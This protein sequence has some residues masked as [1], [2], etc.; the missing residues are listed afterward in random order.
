[1]ACVSN[2]QIKD[3]ST[4]NLKYTHID[5]KKQHFYLKT[6]YYCQCYYIINIIVSSL[7]IIKNNSPLWVTA[8]VSKLFFHSQLLD[9]RSSGENYF[10]IDPSSG[11]LTLIEALDYE[12]LKTHV[13]IVTA[14]DGVNQVK[15]NH[16]H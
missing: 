7:C 10:S 9:G 2:D 16:S 6:N 5:D 1:M 13:I 12:V 15:T 4:T 3:S 8:T 11:T 14:T